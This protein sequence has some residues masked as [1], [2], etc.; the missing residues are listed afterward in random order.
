MKTLAFEIMLSSEVSQMEAIPPLTFIFCIAMASCFGAFIL[1]VVLNLLS[2]SKVRNSYVVWAATLQNHEEQTLG[3]QAT[4]KNKLVRE[5]AEEVA[6]CRHIS[7]FWHATFGT[8][9]LC[10]LCV[11]GGTAMTALR[12][13]TTPLIV[14]GA[15]AVGVVATVGNGLFKPRVL[16]ERSLKRAEMLAAERRKAEAD[17]ITIPI[18]DPEASIKRQ[19]VIERLIASLNQHP[20]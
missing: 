4:T 10:Q 16:A 14:A 15:G 17:W 11:T 18:S 2:M 3:T 12:Q 13:Y 1:I 5:I 8:F 20:S 9:T 7:T 19:A 6:W